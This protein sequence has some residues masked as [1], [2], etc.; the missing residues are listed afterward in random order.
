MFD[1][2]V[3]V[4]V[5]E[6]SE[7]DVLAGLRWQWHCERQVPAE[8]RDSFITRFRN[9]YELCPHLALVAELNGEVIGMAWLAV[10]SRLPDP[11]AEAVT[12]ADLQSVYL[13]PEHRGRG[14]GTELVDAA[15]AH[16]GR[17]GVSRVTVLAGRRS[18]SL[19]ERHGFRPDQQLLVFSGPA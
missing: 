1:G 2:V 16:A 9:W 10:V 14:L 5:A 8:D 4:R 17:L 12:H 6:R 18:T 3:D 7:V 15:L 13:V 11:D 19:Y